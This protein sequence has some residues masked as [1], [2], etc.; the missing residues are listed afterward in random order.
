MTITNDLLRYIF[1]RSLKSVLPREI[2]SRG[3]M[4]FGIPVH[5][6]F[7]NELKDYSQDIL[8]SEKCINREYFKKESVKNMLDEHM[9]GKVNHGSR[10]WSLLNLELWHRMFIDGKMEYHFRKE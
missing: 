2:L 5:D 7:R 9:S 6:W 3:K 8:M 4:G 1:K 10:I